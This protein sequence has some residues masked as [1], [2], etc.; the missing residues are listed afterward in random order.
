[1]NPE[2]LDDLLAGYAKRTLPTVTGPSQADV[3]RE[4]E[5]RRKQSVWTRM[6]SVLE[7]RELFGEPRLTLA[8][9][10]FA[11]VVGIVPAALVSRMQ[12]EQR[13]ARQ[14][15]HFEVFATDSASLGFVFT[16]PVAPASGLKR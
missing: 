13:L 6:F 3:W 14:S 16:T 9:V 12:N 15:I 2:S 1:M 8:A 10:A 11:L 4:V 7:L 5:R